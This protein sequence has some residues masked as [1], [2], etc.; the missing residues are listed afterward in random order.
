MGCPVSA[1]TRSVCGR[2]DNQ[3]AAVAVST[4]GRLSVSKSGNCRCALASMF[5]LSQVLNM[6]AISQIC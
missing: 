4:V 2:L 6:V 1:Y 3:W 5:L